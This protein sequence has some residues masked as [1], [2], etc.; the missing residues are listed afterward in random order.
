MVRNGESEKEENIEIEVPRMT[1]PK[2]SSQGAVGDAWPPG[3]AVQ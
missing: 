1:L 2:A 3:R